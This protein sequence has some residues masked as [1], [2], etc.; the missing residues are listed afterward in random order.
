MVKKGINEPEIDID[1]HIIHPPL[2]YAKIRALVQEQ[3]FN[4]RKENI[5][6]ARFIVGKG[7]HSQGEPLIPTL[8]EGELHK[9]K[10]GGLIKSFAIEKLSN[11]EENSGAFIVILF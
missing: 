2:P 11:G 5:R 8:V 9:A 3:L 7:L 6:I 1:F 10:E 4:L